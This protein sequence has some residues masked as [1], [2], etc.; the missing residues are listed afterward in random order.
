MTKSGN[1]VRVAVHHPDANNT[2]ATQTITGPARIFG[3]IAS[4]N[5]DPAAGN[6]LSIVLSEGSVTWGWWIFKAGPVEIPG[7]Y[8]EVPVGA[9][10]IVTL[11]AETSAKGTINVLWQVGRGGLS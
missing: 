9:T 1:P 11:P 8:V 2:A 4:Y 5:A 10:A 3:V 7:G 6:F